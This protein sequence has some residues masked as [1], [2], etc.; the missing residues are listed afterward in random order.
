MR[1][2]FVMVLAVILLPF[3]LVWSAEAQFCQHET[4]LN[5]AHFG[6]HACINHLYNDNSSSDIQ[7][8]LKDDTSAQSAD[9]KF[10]LDHSH[11]MAE[12]S[13]IMPSVPMA[14]EQLA[15]Q[16]SATLFQ[17]HIT[18]YES[19]PKKTPEVPIWQ[20]FAAGGVATL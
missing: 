15:F 7:S 17:T 8:N 16:Q 4:R 20:Q 19:I 11:H 12:M 5:T 2:F 3:Q 14:G 10:S 18:L 13:F 1:F 9:K 6:H